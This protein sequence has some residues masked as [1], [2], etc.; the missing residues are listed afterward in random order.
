MR[1]CAEENNVH[2]VVALVVVSSVY[3]CCDTHEPHP[4]TYLPKHRE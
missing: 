3:V 2:M 1:K 4:T